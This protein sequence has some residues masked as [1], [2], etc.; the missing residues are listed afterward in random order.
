MTDN[1]FAVNHLR[2]G[3]NLPRWQGKKVLAGE[4]ER[5]YDVVTAFTASGYKNKDCQGETGTGFAVYKES[6]FIISQS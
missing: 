3:V 1:L 6:W 2:R 5:N 4:G